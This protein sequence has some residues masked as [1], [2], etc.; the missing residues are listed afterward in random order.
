LAVF[1]G[2]NAGDGSLSAGEKNSCRLLRD[3]WRMSLSDIVMA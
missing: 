3:F 1:V 2:A